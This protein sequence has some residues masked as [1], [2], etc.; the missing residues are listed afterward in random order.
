MLDLEMLARV[1]NIVCHDNCADGTVSAMFLHDAL[2]HAQIQFCQYGASQEKLEV[3]PNMLFCDFSPHESKYLDFVEAGAVIL[4]HHKSA[5]SIVE[6]FGKH[7]VFA[8]EATEPGVSGAMMAFRHVWLHLAP[9]R[10]KYHDVKYAS[11]IARLTGIRDTW[12][13]HDPEWLTACELGETIRFFS[14]GSWLVEKPFSRKHRAWWDSRLAVG[15]RLIEKQQ[16]TL[17]KVL[18]GAYN[19]SSKAGT[20]VV[21]FPGTTL[22]SD[23]CELVKET[24][25]L[26]VGF[27]YFAIEDG[28]AALGYSL[29][30]YASSPFDCQA[31]C[32]TLGGGG[33]SKAAGFSVRFDPA[34][35]TGDPYSLF[36]AR[37]GDYEA[38]A[39]V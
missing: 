21:L 10:F 3:R 22:T 34:L 31:F 11:D 27:D 13:K 8:D 16:V 26:I 23:A 39:R 18:S 7:G 4:D 12:Q 30:S 32:K 6:A 5:R 19:F 33:H 15:Q 24:A 29:R 36:R 38:Q 37:L 1:S 17:R 28:Q 20:R 25:D 14:Q 2:P 35:G 9:G